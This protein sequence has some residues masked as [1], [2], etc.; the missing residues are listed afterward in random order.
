MSLKAEGSLTAVPSESEIEYRSR[1]VV[2]IGVS[3]DECSEGIE[4][5]GSAAAKS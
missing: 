4:H 5:A 3:L 2:G 1:N